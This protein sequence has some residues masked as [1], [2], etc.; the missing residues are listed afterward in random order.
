M[1]A[2]GLP[3]TA[4]LAI[5]ALHKHDVKPAIQAIAGAGLN[6]RK[7]RRAVVEHHAFAHG[8]ELIV[9]DLAANPQQI[10]ALNPRRG[11]H[12]AIGQFAVGGKDQQSRGVVIQ[13]PHRNPAA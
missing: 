12:Q 1:Q 5:A 11:V 3:Q 7:A 4:H 9:T 10:L 8:L 6:I 2:L 13:A